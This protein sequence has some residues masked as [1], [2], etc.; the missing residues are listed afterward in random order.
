VILLIVVGFGVGLLAGV[1]FEEPDLVLGG[2]AGEM[3]DVD[4]EA[5]DGEPEAPE[6]HREDPLPPLGS[7]VARRDPAGP[8]PR[9][10]PRNEGARA[11]A[12]PPVAAPAAVSA[13]PPGGGFSVQVGAFSES[14]SAD[15]L[16]GSL[17][18]GG[19]PVY[20]QKD[21]GS[22]KARW[23]VR[24]GPVASRD[25]AEQLAARLEGEQQLPTWILAEPS[26]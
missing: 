9:A 21:T 11:P 4:L 7:D 10:A 3:E 5:I 18:K 24:V 16:R 22:G 23:R 12:P 26:H 14:A 2:M 17:R 6:A 1:A 25:E 13:P 20:V 8:A 19:F 15:R